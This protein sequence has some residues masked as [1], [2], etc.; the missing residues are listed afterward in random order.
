MCFCAKED[1]TVAGT[2]QQSTRWAGVAALGLGI[3]MMTTLEQLPIGVLT[4]VADDFRVD[5]GVIGLGVTIPG[6]LAGVTAIV[7]PGLFGRTDRRTL[8]AGAVFLGAA[9]GVVSAVSTSV[10]VFLAS[11]ILVG[12][13]LGVFWSL[14]GATVAR[15]AAPQQ[16][17][18]ALTVAFSGTAAAIVLGIP[19]AT[20]LGN[21]VGWK[22]A[23]AIVAAAAAATGVAVAATVPASQGGAAGKMSDLKKAAAIPGLRFGVAFTL[24]MVTANFTAYTYASP[25]LQDKA[26][27]TASGVAGVLLAAGVA[28]MAGNFLAGPMMRRCLVATVTA[29]PAGVA[30]AL[31]VFIFLVDS[32][33]TGY[34]AM[35][36]WGVFAGMISVVSQGWVLAYAGDYAEAAS[37]LN[38]GAF[39]IAIAMGALIGGG[40][41]AGWLAPTGIGVVSGGT[42]AVLVVA[43]CATLA[44]LVLAATGRRFKKAAPTTQ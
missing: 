44:A 12:L 21:A 43:V 35:L 13:G 23:F 14:L 7:A 17:A 5:N 20:F 28:G 19:V 33:A 18:T 27:V 26:G 9:S 38:S 2:Q 25:I 15:L 24:L 1:Q 4:L 6:L 37:G 30:A 11:R 32:P 42:D 29:I 3:F 36:L 10:P 39:N 40:V 16:V 41:E 8:L 31:S 34:A 22:A